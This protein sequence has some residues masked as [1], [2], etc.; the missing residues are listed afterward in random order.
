MTR[1]PPYD[2]WDFLVEELPPKKSS[3]AN[4]LPADK[5]S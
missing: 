3:T 4:T 1:M 2:V 5:V